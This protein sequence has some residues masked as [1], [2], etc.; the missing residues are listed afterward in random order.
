M[1]SFLKLEVW[2]C[3]LITVPRQN[4]VWEQLGLVEFGP[5][6]DRAV[7]ARGSKAQAKLGDRK[8]RIEG[9]N[10]R[11]IDPT[12]HERYSRQWHFS[13]LKL[14]GAILV[15]ASN[16]NQGRSLYPHPTFQRVTHPRYLQMFTI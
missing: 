3:Q 4:K 8:K 14:Q 15:G 2:D 6:Y 11:D 5:E 9:L 13:P 7:L 12:Q 10:I 1:I 16:S